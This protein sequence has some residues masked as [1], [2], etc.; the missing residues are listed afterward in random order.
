M[1]L[2]YEEAAEQLERFRAADAVERR[3]QRVARLR[4]ATR[5]AARGFLPDGEL[6]YWLGYGSPD[7]EG[8]ALERLSD[9]DRRAVL[10]AL[11]PGLGGLVDAN[12][13]RGFGQPYQTGWQRRAF[14]APQ[15]PAATLPARLERVL[16]TLHSLGDYESPEPP[17]VARWAA[18]LGRGD[19][20][21]H[22][23]AAAIDQGDSD[24]DE[25][26]D[27]LIASAEGTDAVASM[28]SHVVIAL[29][30]SARQD[31]W[32][33]V[34]RLLV[35]AQ[36]Q[37]GLRQAILESVDEAH[38][39]AFRQML[40]LILEH[41]LTRF[42][43]TVRAADVWFGFAYDVGGARRIESAI[44]RT[45][46]YLDDRDARTDA[47]TGGEP[48][49]AYLAVW[50]VAYEDAE[51]AIPIAAG[52]LESDSVEHRYVGASLLGQ[53]GLTTS[54]EALLP[55][56]DD[57]DV[58]VATLAA[59][60]FGRLAPEHAPAGL[61]DR[62][63]ALIERVGAAR[64][65][66]APIVW[67]WTGG[68]L[69]R[70]VIADALVHHGAEQ[71]TDRLLRRLDVLSPDA[72]RTVATRLRDQ[73]TLSARERP[74][75]LRLVGDASVTVRAPALEALERLPAPADET[76]EL[77]A[78]LSRKAG[79]L[80]RGVV[81][82]LLKQDD[83]S[84]LASADR[85]LASSSEP[86]RLAGLEILRRLVDDGRSAETARVRASDYVGSRKSLAAAERAQLDAI[87]APTGETHSL[88][89]ALGLLDATQRTAPLVPRPCGAALVSP[90][91]VA[92]IASLDAFVHEHR[93][94]PIVVHGW[95]DRTETVL[96]GDAGWQF[97][98][99]APWQ[100]PTA[101]GRFDVE[102]AAADRL[103]LRE[104][105]ERWDAERDAPTRD[106]DGLEL[107]RALAI[108]TQG[109]DRHSRLYGT[110]L[111]TGATSLLGRLDRPIVDYQAVVQSVLEWLAWLTLPADGPAF[112][113]DA[114]ETQLAS[115][116]AGELKDQHPEHERGWLSTWREQ[117]WI[118]YLELVRRARRAR[119]DR[120]TP[121]QHL[122]LWQLERWVE[123]PPDPP[124]PRRRRRGRREPLVRVR[125]PLEELLIAAEL[126]I[127]TDADL[128][129]HLLGPRG[130]H[131]GFGALARLTTRALALARERTR[132]ADLAGLCRERILAVELARGE[133]PTAA[134]SPALNLGAT[135]GIDVLVPLLV[136][137]GKDSFIRGWTYD[138]VARAT[139]FSRLIRS[140][141]PPHGDVPERFA[142]AVGEAHIPERRLVELAAFAPQ[143]A[144]HVERAVG[145]AG[146]ESAV[147]WL[148]AHTKDNA[149]SVDREVREVWAAEIAERTRLTSEEL[150][151]GAVDVEWFRDAYAALGGERWRTL[152][153]AAKYGSTGAGH[154]RAQLYADAMRGA[155]DE[156]AILTRISDKR[157]QDG[158]RALGLLP[159]PAVELDGIVLRRY[160]AI[161]EFSRGSRTFGSQRQ[162]SERRAAEIGLANLAR[163][164]GY[165]D[166]VRLEW[167]MEAR[168]VADLAD[169]P[170][171]VAVDDVV[172]S[173]GLDDAGQP[174]VGVRRG[175]RQLKAV[176][177]AVAKTAEVKALRKRA[178]ELRRQGSRI[179]TSLEAAM[180]RGD[181]F[182]GAE[183][184]E[185][186]SHPVLAPKLRKLVLVGEGIVGYPGADGRVLVDPD[187]ARQA[188]GPTE[189][190]RIAH[191][192]DLYETGRWSDWQRDCL[193]RETVQPFKQVFR[194][195]YLATD[196]ELEATAGSARYAGH[197]LQ[198][199]QALTLLGGRGWVA[200]P[201]EG[202]RKTFHDVGL[203]AR[204]VFLEGW[205]SPTEVEGLTLE[206]VRFTPKGEWSTV[207]IT[208]VP[209]RVFSEVM[210]DLDL[211][212][213]VAH[214][215]G[216]DPEASQSTIEMR[217]ALL[218]ETLGLLDLDNVRL[219][220]S[221]ALIDGRLGEYSVH[222]GSAVVHRRPGG[223]VCIVPV[224]GQHRG[225]LFLPFADDDPKT[226]EVVSKV[227][228]LA[229]DHEI[230]DPTILEQLR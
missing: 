155:L 29:L 166:P 135:G 118:G 101:D 99:A 30:A 195:L 188:V 22:L 179:R 27:L 94:E 197:Q 98:G 136:A 76:E 111:G 48:E 137:L 54:Y 149:W 125:P 173:L 164:A 78:L 7:D 63:D 46:R 58:R 69:D 33:F 81:S 209:R 157:H 124:A 57:D 15:S 175:D 198:P 88:D 36:R 129:D 105:W 55:A 139:V 216:V 134:S 207:A 49:D 200:H 8:A 142:E 91:A 13:K 71:P 82:L 24:G 148:H 192:L 1:P 32:A 10:D 189:I 79:D 38:P 42:S 92:A 144:T 106:P 45:S 116:P 161:Q 70:G 229:R 224:H 5:A 227:L 128:I 185:L 206:H 186:A 146:L 2:P 182:S 193:A 154:K 202:V 86:K 74:G 153:G 184:H 108:P 190:V 138:G 26:L 167:A 62:L 90:A 31:G 203:T 28:G 72:R 131:E 165:A 97:A 102:R 60:S 199:R 104:L 66:V 210:R 159:L 18:Y 178:T 228:L 84:A 44:E 219:D 176:P 225:R 95:D 51:Q 150:L 143:W 16:L 214:A 208:E 201:D 122:R 230:Q 163:T 205:G 196:A 109:S 4:G 3:A 40:R 147:W 120:W 121:E 158:V 204:L 65:T 170:L 53:I 110:W 220:A 68:A 50:A 23:L 151:E 115:I 96:L 194:E 83:E 218:E 61:F 21:G 77:E 43:A 127:A 221:W 39:D 17:W 80:R 140:S 152:D 19:T 59:T 171:T 67:P 113:L 47:I 183:L 180:T 212:V 35:A 211:V 112:L 34:E 75:L 162:A 177:P 217:S 12:W 169:G 11:L 174:E 215:G 123:L 103:Q 6:P 41:G 89:D 141:F 14:R 100:H 20:F 168:G 93:D 145:W 107:V 126:G 114:T 9:R 133:A 222:L 187:G 172:V 119:F 132:A 181:T 73:T 160:E 85:L 64:T 156:Q 213:S 223:S 52:L 130:R 56:L 37:E 226:A 191:P 117:G 87:T 25:V